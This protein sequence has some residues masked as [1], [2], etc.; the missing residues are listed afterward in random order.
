MSPAPTNTSGPGM[1]TVV[2]GSDGPGTVG[3][4]G[5]GRRRGP[6]GDLLHWVHTRHT[7]DSGDARREPRARKSTP[8]H[9]VHQNLTIAAN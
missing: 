8:T 6:V 1:G 5:P 9:A 4:P 2:G 7:T 3:F